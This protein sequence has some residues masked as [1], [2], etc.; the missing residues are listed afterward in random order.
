M[1]SE[2]IAVA[3]RA[4]GLTTRQLG[5]AAGVSAM[6]ISKYENGKATPASDV[7]LRLASA[8][9]VRTEYFFRSKTVELRELEFRKH[10]R[11]PK[12]LQR[13]IEANATDQMERFLEL[14]ELV[15][16]EAIKGSGLPRVRARAIN[17]MDQIEGVADAVRKEWDLGSNP[18]ADLA[19]TFEQ[20]GIRVFL[21][22]LAGDGPFSGLAAMVDKMPIVVVSRHHPGDRQRFTLAHE[23]GHLVLAKFKL[24]GTLDVEMA[25]NRFAGAFLV[26]KDKALQKLGKKRSWLEPKELWNL[27]AEWGLS[28]AGWVHRANELGVVSD[29]KYREI[30]QYFQTQGWGLKEPFAAFPQERPRLMETLVLRALAEDWI[31]ESKAAELLGMPVMDFRKEILAADADPRR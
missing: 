13:K 22:D 30:R 10:P 28:M 24:A 26:P 8:L 17:D 1:L 16:A 19:D 21:T 27:K 29:G 3:R 23:L 9:G 11:L 15:P 6:S 14:A 12:A 7:L 20:N 25:A 4:A 5:E 2:R 18:I 31:G